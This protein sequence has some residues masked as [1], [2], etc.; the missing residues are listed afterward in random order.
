MIFWRILN[1]QRLNVYECD[2]LGFPQSDAKYIPDAYLSNQNFVILRTCFGIGDWGIISALPR[3]LKKE[4]P[5]CKV[6]LPSETLLFKLFADILNP[7][8][9]INKP[10]GVV[11]DIFANNP[12]VDGYVDSCD[13][14]IF[15][16]HYRIYD[17]NKPNEPLAKQ[18]LKFWQFKDHNLEDVLPEVYFSKSEI[19]LGD[20]IIKGFTGDNPFGTLLLSNRYDYQS[21]EKLLKYIKLYD[22]PY[23]YWTSKPIENTNFA[24]INKVLD[25]AI[26]PL[27]IQLYIKTRALVNIGNQSGM[28]DTI[29][30]YT[31]NITLQRQFPLG[32]NFVETTQ[33]I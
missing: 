8:T 17:T 15:H 10:F 28:N 19:S 31:K 25:M 3:K 23:Y 14:D 33:Y 9:L 6:Y 32:G 16:D 1:N 30:K 12:Y 13:G 24:N 20:K 18:I 5:N 2:V 4:Y 21:D 29:S 27:R 22:L 11:K 7:A 26:L